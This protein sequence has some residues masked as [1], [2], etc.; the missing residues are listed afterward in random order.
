MSW[1]IQFESNMTLSGANADKR[2][3]LRP[4]EIKNILFKLYSNLA[5]KKT[6]ISLSG[7]NQ[8]LLDQILNKINRS[9]SNSVVI[10]GIDDD[11]CQSLILAINSI[12]RA[13]HLM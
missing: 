9:P 10:S 1:H 3:A 11:Y 13:R 2:V 4:S 5:N 12:L 8:K 7:E 6:S